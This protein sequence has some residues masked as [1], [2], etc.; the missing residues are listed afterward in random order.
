MYVQV[1]LEPFPDRV[2]FGEGFLI[3]PFNSS[4]AKTK[5]IC[6]LSLRFRGFSCRKYWVDW[7]K[8]WPKRNKRVVKR[9]KVHSRRNKHI[10]RMKKSTRKGVNMNPL[11][12]T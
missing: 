7:N 2:I 9:N 4:V 1:L 3:L 5:P 11:K 8:P 6:P 12:T 10:M